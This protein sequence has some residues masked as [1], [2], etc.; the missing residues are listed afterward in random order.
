VPVPHYAPLDNALTRPFWDGVGAGELRLPRC[1]ACGR[2]QWYPL[3]VLEHGDGGYF[4]WVPV[5]PSGTVFTHTTV[6]RPFLPGASKDDVPYTV[7][8]VELD[9]V[10]GVRFVGRLR[11]GD[12]PAIGQRVTAEFFERD[13]RPDVQFVPA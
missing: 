11:D 10:P 9:G 8:F 1:S 6:R 12:Q 13:D 2:Y 3:P 4:E 5:A 7:V